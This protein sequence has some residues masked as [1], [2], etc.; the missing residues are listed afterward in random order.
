MI[1]VRSYV[2]IQ[3]FPRVSST[4][5]LLYHFYIYTNPFGFHLLALLVMQLFLTVFMIHCVR[6]YEVDAFYRGLVSIDQPRMAYNM[7]PWPTWMGALAPDL[8][9]FM[10]L[11]DRTMDIYQQQVPVHGG[12]PMP[13]AGGVA[14]AGVVGSGT[15]IASDIGGS[16]RGNASHYQSLEHTAM[17]PSG[18]VVSTGSIELNTLASPSPSASA[19]SSSRSTVMSLGG[20][21]NNGHNDNELT[22]LGPGPSSNESRLITS[23]VNPLLRGEA[24]RIRIGSNVSS[25]AAVASSSASSSS[26]TTYSRLNRGD[27]AD[28]N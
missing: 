16:I 22:R 7:T 10:P 28:D 4:L 6:K 14:H 17:P 13:P 2:S 19:A 23:S 26:S 5:F 8:T 11:S 9:V 27:D 24:T 21:G 3:L 1:Y 15:G 25:A 18:A 12:V 20:V